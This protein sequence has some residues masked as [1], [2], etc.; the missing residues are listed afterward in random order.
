MSKFFGIL[1]SLIALIMIS[2]STLAHAEMISF[3]QFAEREKSFYR[4]EK[5]DHFF[6]YA[7]FYRKR[8]LDKNFD[9]SLILLEILALIKHCQVEP[10]NRLI[11][12]GHA[13]AKQFQTPYLETK[14]AD[15]QQLLDLQLSYPEAVATT[16][17][18]HSSK[19]FKLERQWR[20]KSQDQDRA[21]TRVVR[22]PDAA[23]VYVEN[24]CTS[25]SSAQGNTS[26]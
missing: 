15:L 20:M 1:F 26:P 2:S 16:Q 7:A 5:W 23:L 12:Q 22:N 21:L 14:L 11:Q 3:A 13:L 19:I 8:L 18:K 4:Q 24:R 9:P 10:A 17:A 25:L 6:G